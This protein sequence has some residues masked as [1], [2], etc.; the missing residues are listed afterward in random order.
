MYETSD[1]GVSA[2]GLPLLLAASTGRTT[3]HSGSPETAGLDRSFSY[4]PLKKSRSRLCVALRLVL[5]GSSTGDTRQKKAADSRLR[6]NL[7]PLVLCFDAISVG[8]RAQ[9]SRLLETRMF[10][11]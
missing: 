10:P 6:G 9:V 11:F 3:I 2:A 7:R 1:I 4:T 5:G 8:S